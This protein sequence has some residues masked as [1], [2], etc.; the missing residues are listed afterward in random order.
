MARK[1]STETIETEI[2]KIKANMTRLQDRYNK[3]A[4]KLKELQEQKRRMEADVIMD[5]YLRSGKSFDEIMTFLT[6]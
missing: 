5:A 1:R 3:L 2:N 6:P 4:D